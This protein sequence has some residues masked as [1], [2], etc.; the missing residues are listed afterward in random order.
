MPSQWERLCEILERAETMPA[1][2]RSSYV[3]HAINALAFECS[4]ATK[5]RNKLRSM[6]T[7]MQADSVGEKPRKKRR[8]ST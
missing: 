7:K 2:H 4:A 1:K 8:S 5:A 6:P 3:N